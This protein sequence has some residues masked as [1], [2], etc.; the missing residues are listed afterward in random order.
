MTEFLPLDA[1]QFPYANCE[2][3][4]R[5]KGKA[6]T[7]IVKVL[8]TYENDWQMIFSEPLLQA[9]AE[10]FYPDYKSGLDEIA[11]LVA[12]GYLEE[13]IPRYTKEA[14]KR[15]RVTAKLVE[16]CDGYFRQLCAAGN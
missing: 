11:A 16:Q 1:T 9:Y 13:V 5:E 15:F 8:A 14:P 4:S 3:F 12:E 6:V 2:G 10:T 7:I